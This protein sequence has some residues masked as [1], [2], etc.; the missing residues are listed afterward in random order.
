MVFAL[1]LAEAVA[2]R[3]EKVVVS[4]DDRAVQ[5]E[6]NDRLG[7]IDRFDLTRKISVLELLLGD[8][9][10]ELNDL[11]RLAVEVEDGVVG[12]LNPDLLAAL[13]DALVLRRL[14]LAAV[15]CLPELAVFSALPERVL[16]ED[17]VVF[18]L[19]LAEAVAQR[20]EKVIV[21]RDDRAVQVEFNDRLRLVNRLDLTREI[22]GLELLLGDIGGE[23]DD[24]EQF[25]VGPDNRVVGGLNPDLFAALAETLELRR[26]VLTAAERL[27]ELAILGARP[28]GVVD[29][30]AVVLA[31]DLF[32]AVTHGVEE[33]IIGRDDRTVQ[34]ELDDGLGL[35]ERLHRVRSFED[36]RGE[37]GDGRAAIRFAGA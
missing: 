13:T 23:L 6:F 3:A 17:A 26:L 30:D 8:I 24:L 2:Q 15:Q 12:G 36:M 35:A 28:V 27:P 7:L 19:H 11:K 16:D 20:V 32:Q 4:R 22:S 34:L 33:V 25:V 9:G 37:F 31:L 14:V 18:A 1:H 21:G 29:E 10:G 5:V